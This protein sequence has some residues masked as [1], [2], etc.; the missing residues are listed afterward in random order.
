ME[1]KQS[2]VNTHSHLAKKRETLVRERETLL[3]SFSTATEKKHP[4]RIDRICKQI[5]QINDF[6]SSLDQIEEETQHRQHPG[7]N[8]YV[9]STLFLHESFKELTKD[10]NEQ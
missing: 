10:K 3:A 4:K 8:R 1:Q 5:C 9:V 7:I 6:L 2:R